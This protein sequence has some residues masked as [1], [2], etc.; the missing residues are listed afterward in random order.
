MVDHVSGAQNC[1]FK[2]YQQVVRQTL[3]DIVPDLP[4]EILD[5]V[6]LTPTKDPLHGDM[7][8]NGAL[9]AAKPARRKPQEIAASLAK[10]LQQKEEIASA[11]AAGLV[12]STSPSPPEFIRIC[13]PVSCV[14][15]R[16][17]GKAPL[18]AGSASMWNMFQPTRQARCMSGTAAARLLVMRSP[19]CFRRPDMPS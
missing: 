2:Q 11:E 18:A 12:L 4:D 17:M 3:R 10:R 1:L 15:V 13:F 5:R 7:A 6:E 9:L 8:T 19:A 16:R 14:R